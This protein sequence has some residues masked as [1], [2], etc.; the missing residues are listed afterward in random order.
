[1][2]NALLCKSKFSHSNHTLNF[3]EHTDQYYVYQINII[4]NQTQKL[5][6]VTVK[7]K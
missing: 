4:E 2:Q 1:M 6:P 5:D 3:V 7:L